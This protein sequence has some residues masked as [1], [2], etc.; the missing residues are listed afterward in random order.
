MEPLKKLRKEYSPGDV[1][2]VSICAGGPKKTWEDLVKRLDLQ[3]PGIDC[4]YQT[5]ISDENSFYKILNRL[6]LKGYP[7]YL[8]LNREGIIVDYGTVVRP[9][10]PRTKQFI[11]SV[12]PIIVNLANFNSNCFC[13]KWVNATVAFAFPP[14][15]SIAMTSPSPKRS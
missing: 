9:S 4:L 1:V 6:E 10:D 11:V 8:L 5:D 15:P 13:P 7:H 3:Q 14:S 12:Y 2:I